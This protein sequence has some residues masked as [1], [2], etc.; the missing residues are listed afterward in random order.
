M[1][2]DL[3]DNE[4]FVHKHLPE[5]KN[6]QIIPALRQV[7]RKIYSIALNED[8]EVGQVI[9]TAG[10]KVYYYDLKQPDS[11]QYRSREDVKSITGVK[12]APHGAI[13][14][15][16]VD[17]EKWEFADIIAGRVFDL[18]Q[19]ISPQSNEQAAYDNTIRGGFPQ[20]L[21]SDHAPEVDRLRNYMQSGYISQYEYD[22]SNPALPKAG[23]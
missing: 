23:K 2:V 8:G 9:F 16:F 1:S 18:A 15:E 4:Q 21:D 20:L 12:A 6:K 11:L 22:D 3:A 19:A 14:I 17:K 7:S 13:K 5:V 10:T